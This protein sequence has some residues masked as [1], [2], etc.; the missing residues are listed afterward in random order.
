MYWFLSPLYDKASDGCMSMQDVAGTQHV[1]RFVKSKS[2][3]DSLEGLKL[4]NVVSKQPRSVS[5]SF[6]KVYFIVT[7]FV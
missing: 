3:D 2:T 5:S 7:M 4:A 1:E 6:F